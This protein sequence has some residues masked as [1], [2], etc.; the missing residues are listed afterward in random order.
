MPLKMSPLTDEH[1]NKTPERD[2]RHV[3][4]SVMA[5]YLDVA[6]STVWKRHAAGVYPKTGIKQIGSFT[7]YIPRVVMGFA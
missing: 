5:Q 7:Y 6:P 3:P 1:G 4:V 2:G